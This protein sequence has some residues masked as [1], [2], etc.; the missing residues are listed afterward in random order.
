[1]IFLGGL[2]GWLVVILDPFVGG[3][4]SY[5]RYGRFVAAKEP[6]L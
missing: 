5:A 4:W 2:V 6:W 3:A 1:M